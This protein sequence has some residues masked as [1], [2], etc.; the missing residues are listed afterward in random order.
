M[1]TIKEST[2]KEMCQ[3]GR[4]DEDRLSSCCGQKAI[5]PGQDY[6]SQGNEDTQDLFEQWMHLVDTENI[7]SKSEKK[8]N[9]EWKHKDS[10]IV[11]GARHLDPGNNYIFYMVEKERDQLYKQVTKVFSKKRRE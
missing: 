5:S 10:R 9:S 2:A 3:K 1:E 7:E 11:K 8:K 4:W 6:L